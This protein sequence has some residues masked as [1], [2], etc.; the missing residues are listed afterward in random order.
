MLLGSSVSMLLGSSVGMLLGPSDQALQII[1][2][3][4][5]DKFIIIIIVI[6]YLAP[7]C[8]HQCP[9]RRL[10]ALSGRASLGGQN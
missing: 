6:T 5:H 1:N 10:S 9:P 7:V 4:I 8:A 3:Y 2:R